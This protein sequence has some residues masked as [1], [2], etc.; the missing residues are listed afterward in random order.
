MRWGACVVVACCLFQ[1]VCFAAE[2]YFPAFSSAGG[3]AGYWYIQAVEADKASRLICGRGVKM[4]VVDSGVDYTHPDIASH[5][6]L[7]FAYDF[8]DNDT[9]IMDYLGHGTAVAGIISKLAPCAKIIPLKINPGSSPAFSD[10]NLKRALRYVLNLKDIQPN[11]KIV[12]LSITLAN[13][14]DDV[15]S[16]ITELLKKGVVVVAAS[17]NDGEKKISFP[18]SV[19]GVIAVSSLNQQDAVSSFSNYSPKVF[20]SA[21]GEEMEVSYPNGY[22]FMSGTSMASAVVSGVAAALAEVVPV[23]KLPLVIAKGSVDE[24]NPGYDEFYGFGK[25]D[26]LKSLAAYFSMDFPLFPSRCHLSPEERKDLYFLPVNKA[27]YFIENATVVQVA[28]FDPSHGSI[29]VKA[30]SVG[31]TFVCVY[32]DTK[33]GCSFVVVGEK[34]SYVSPLFF[35]GNLFVD[36]HVVNNLNGTYYATSTAFKDR[37]VSRTT[38]LYAGKLPYGDFVF[39]LP[40]DEIP[41]GEGVKEF[42]ICGDGLICGRDIF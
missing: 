31:K 39:Q 8:G 22:T 38:I 26:M 5:L 15:E 37:A 41:E 6:Y 29:T 20:I 11:I 19:P 24:G 10:N 17:G 3:G 12:N 35:Y 13:P 36:L 42:L 40:A 27:G 32:S 14:D 30:L 21:P 28:S 7:D 1:V 4:V 23:D 33:A 25:V 34:R 18:A 9:D 2:G 16:L